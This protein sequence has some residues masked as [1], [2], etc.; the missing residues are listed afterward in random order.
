M[1]SKIKIIKWKTPQGISSPIRVKQVES[2]KED[3][4]A[5]LRHK[6]AFLKSKLYFKEDCLFTV[7]AAD[8]TSLKT[9]QL[10]AD[11]W[12]EFAKNWF[13]EGDGKIRFGVA[14]RCKIDGCRL[15]SWF[16]KSG[17]VQKISFINN[18]N[19]TDSRWK[20]C[21]KMIFKRGEN[22]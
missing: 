15:H 12:F 10:S 16:L 17:Y 6:T 11:K 8:E 19:P 21:R 20:S 9:C 3:F 14:A 13:V 7:I 4:S 22:L 2:G 5:E 1:H 18:A